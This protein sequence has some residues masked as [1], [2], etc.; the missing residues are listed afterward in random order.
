MLRIA[1]PRSGRPR[2]T[3]QDIVSLLKDYGPWG[4]LTLALVV[5]RFLFAGWRDCMH[6]RL[7][8]RDAIVERMAVAL[9]RQASSNADVSVGM[10]EVREGQ[11]QTL[12]LTTE[13]ALSSA[14]TGKAV[15]EKLADARLGIDTLVRGVRS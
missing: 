6:E 15:L 13:N 3:A 5:I 14:S 11:L 9:E 8:D 1:S 2:M 7:A 12:K 4:L 10:K